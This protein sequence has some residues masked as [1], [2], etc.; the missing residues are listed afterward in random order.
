M[1]T[2]ALVQA[3]AAPAALGTSLWIAQGIL[4]LVFTTTGFLKVSRP[5]PALVPMMS[6]VAET[7]TGLVRL[8]GVSELAGAAGVL[9]PSLTRIAPWLTP[10]AAVGLAIVMLLAIPVHVKHHEVSRLGVPILIGLLAAFV[11]WGRF[12]AVPLG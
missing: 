12:Y 4:F 11:A 8:I 1:T 2:I 10:V 6:W 3:A 7:P 5:I 9:L